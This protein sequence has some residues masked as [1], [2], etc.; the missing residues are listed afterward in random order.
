M[1]IGPILGILSIPRSNG[2]P[3]GGGQSESFTEIL[4]TAE[5]MN[6]IAFVFSPLDIDWSKNA[7]WGYRYNWKIQPGEWERDLFPLPSI[8][9]NR[10]PNRTMENREVIKHILVLLKQ[11]YGSRFFNPCFLDKWKTHAILCSNR[12]TL[13]F[14]P[15]TVRLYNPKVI[16]EML[17][18]HGSVYLKP[19]ANSLG[20]EICKVTKLGRGKFFF[21]HQSLNQQRREGLVSNCHELLAELPP[22]NESSEYLVQQAISL[23]ECEGQPFDLRLLIQKNRLGEWQRTGMAARIAGIGGITTHVFY[24]GIRYPAEKAI[25]EAALNHG[26]SPEKIKK[27]L[28]KIELI[29]PEVIEQ[30]SGESFGE[31]EMDLGIDRRGKVWFF[32]ANSKPF[33]FDE[34]LIR[35]KSLVKLIRYVHY[36]DESGNLGH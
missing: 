1:N 27:Q 30:A 31:L 14:L 25:R 19:S 26:F 34:K 17:G 11:K 24:G 2:I 12:Q 21:I 20:N 6:C 33:R 4:I 3:F 36:L 16:P 18:R 10:I 9:Y 23:A 13:A 35:A 28:K 29:F 5:K 22:I 7:V 15:E 32:E 8:I